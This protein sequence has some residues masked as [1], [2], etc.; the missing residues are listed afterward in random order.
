MMTLFKEDVVKESRAMSQGTYTSAVD[1]GFYNLGSKMLL[2]CC[3]GG[4]L[5]LQTFYFIN[6]TLY[7]GNEK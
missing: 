4:N 2:R 7:K 3:S 5:T 6:I 1:L